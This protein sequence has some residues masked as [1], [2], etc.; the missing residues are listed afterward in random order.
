MDKS[1][2]IKKTMKAYLV[3]TNVCTRVVSDED[4][5]ENEELAWELAKNRLIDNI[6]TIDCSCIE[7]EE[8]LECPYGTMTGEETYSIKDYE[9]ALSIKDLLIEMAI[10]DELPMDMNDLNVT[11]IAEIILSYRKSKQ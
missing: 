7:V 8:D 9:V 10:R 3:W 11:G 4:L 2:T 6:L 5:I 1:K